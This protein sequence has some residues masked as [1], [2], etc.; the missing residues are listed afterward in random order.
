MSRNRIASSVIASL[1]LV[2]NTVA[3]SETVFRLGTV[4]PKNSSFHNIVDDMGKRWA[5]QDVKLKIYAGGMRGGEAEMVQHMR[6][7]SLDAALLTA[8]GLSE[9]DPSVEALQSM[10]MMFHSLSEVDY[11]GANLQP[12]MQK[13]LRE[14]GFVVLFWAD[15]GWVRI[16]SKVPVTRPDDLR[17]LKLFTWAGDVKI[18]DLYK[19]N[20]FQPVALETNDIVP[21]L[22]TNMIQAVPMPP[23]VALMTQVFVQA[24][25]MLEI[26]WAPLVG[27]LVV[28]EKSWNKLTPDVQRELARAAAEAGRQMKARNRME[29]D[30]AVAAM[31][32]HKL[33]VTTLSP[34]LEAEWRRVAEQSYPR[35]RGN[36]IPADLFDEITRLLAEYRNN[37]S[38]AA[39]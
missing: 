20:G 10:P 8:V 31:K 25:N 32:K 28:T 17:H 18:F 23:S 16:F 22:Q 38:G 14:K 19:A 35:L 6:N 7:G 11:I 3:A 13:A 24:P 34:A 33:R 12:R 27:A 29:S 36:K 2:C 15:A 30:M 4:A 37:N 21:M 1:A 9:I 5:T 26:D 39:Q